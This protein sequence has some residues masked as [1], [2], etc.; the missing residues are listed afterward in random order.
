MPIPRDDPPPPPPTT[1][2]DAETAQAFWEENNG[3]DPSESAMYTT[4]CDEHVTAP[5]RLM[6]TTS[7]K[8]EFE[9]VASPHAKIS[10]EGRS[11][12]QREDLRREHERL[13][14][15]DKVARQ[16][17][18]AAE[19]ERD[20]V[21]EERRLR[22]AARPLHQGQRIT[23]RKGRALVPPPTPPRVLTSAPGDAFSDARGPPPPVRRV[24]PPTPPRTSKGDVAWHLHQA[25]E[26]ALRENDRLK[27]ELGRYKAHYGELPRTGRRR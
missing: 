3:R 9:I 17:H 6:R 19:A 16:R 24:A 26:A 25:L 11:E 20:R 14:E 23:N 18:H 21:E 5:S 8:V 12:E 13:C 15:L 22:D 4:A 10:E 1:V 2:D 7:G 27:G